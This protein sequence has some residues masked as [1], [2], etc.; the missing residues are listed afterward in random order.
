MADAEGVQELM[1]DTERVKR[2]RTGWWVFLGLA[3]VTTVEIWLSSAVRGTLAY[4]TLTS[5]VKAALIAYYF[6]HVTQAW[7]GEAKR[8]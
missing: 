3:V 2:M 4:L 6:M 5:L 7:R 1:E 8:E